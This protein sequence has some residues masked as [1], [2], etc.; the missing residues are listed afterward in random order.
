MLDVVSVSETEG[1]SASESVGKCTVWGKLSNANPK[2]WN[3][4]AS[5]K[6]M[7]GC[8]FPIDFDLS[9]ILEALDA[10]S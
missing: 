8:S 1:G 4:G 10:G 7:N 2:W 6:K 3:Q 5:G 9:L